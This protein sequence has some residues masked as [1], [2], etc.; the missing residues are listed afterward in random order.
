MLKGFLNLNGKNITMS[1]SAAII[2]ENEKSRII[3][4][5]GG[6]IKMTVN[7]RAPLGVNPG[8]LGVNI[9]S[10]ANLGSVTIQRGHKAYT[11]SGNNSSLT[12]FYLITPQY[13]TGLNATLR[14]NYFNGELNGLN[15]NTISIFK[16]EDSARTWKN[17]GFSG[18]DIT[19]NFIDLAG[20]SSFSQ[21]TI[22]KDTLSGIGVSPIDQRTIVSKSKLSPVFDINI[23][24][25]PARELAKAKIIVT[26]SSEGT[27]T[28]V[29]SQGQVVLTKAIQ[30]QPGTNVLDVDIHNQPAGLYKVIVDLNM[31]GR[32]VL[33]LIKQ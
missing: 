6:V 27:L 17:A 13:N 4:P 15:E 14:F 18:K 33:Q 9:T 30:V 20:I 1:A 19:A 11:T 26:H 25:N 16:S 24:P 29:N 22:G 3:G 21:Y 23:Y 8:N 2:G 10:P 7:L 32:K 5:N 31:N 12:R 28:V